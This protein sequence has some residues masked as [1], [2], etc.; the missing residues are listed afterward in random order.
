MASM[1][2]KQHH[3]RDKGPRRMDGSRYLF[4]SRYLLSILYEAH[5]TY[6]MQRC[7]SMKKTWNDSTL[8]LVGEGPHCCHQLVVVNSERVSRLSLF[9]KASFQCTSLGFVLCTHTQKKKKKVEN[10]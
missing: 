8:A 2:T 6:L 1:L 5:L 10:M 4:S 9:R 3:F 7:E